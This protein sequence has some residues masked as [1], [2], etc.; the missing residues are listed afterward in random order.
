MNYVW[1]YFLLTIL[2]LNSCKVKEGAVIGKYNS[3]EYSYIEL[4]WVNLINTRTVVG[5]V[6]GTKLEVNE[7]SSFYMQTCG[8]I[9]TGNW[10]IKNDSLYLF[11]KN[12]RWKNDS[13]HLYG[14][15][16]KQPEVYNQPLKYKIL[17]NGFVRK[18]LF[19]N[20]EIESTVIERLIKS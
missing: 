19:R 3:K 11:V 6:V 16:K 12:N 8:N 14:F 5:T 2:T 20:N 9:L 17:K 4:I 13:L 10:L 7:D 18:N 1:K 15:E